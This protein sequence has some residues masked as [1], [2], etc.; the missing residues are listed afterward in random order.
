MTDEQALEI[1]AIQ[2]DE[3][4]AIRSQAPV[5]QPAPGMKPAGAP[6]A[7]PPATPPAQSSSPQPEGSPKLSADAERMVQAGLLV[8]G[9]NGTWT[10]RNPALQSFAD[11]YNRFE[12]Y[13][14]ATARRL[15]T[16]FDGYFQERVG[17]LGVA[18]VD[19]VKEMQTQIQ[20]L[21]E[22]LARSQQEQGQSRVDQWAQENSS[23]LF[24]NG[25]QSQL[26]PYAEKYNAFAQQIDAMARQMGQSL[27]TVQI[28][29]RTIEMLTAAGFSPQQSAQ[30]QMAPAQQQPANPYAQA[31]QQQPAYPQPM[32]V[33]AQPSPSFIQQAAQTAP[34]LQQNRLTEHIAQQPNGI[35]HLST[36]KSGKPKLGSL[37]AFQQQNGHAVT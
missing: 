25:D 17:Q 33:P 6:P 23:H 26:T 19:T 37:I 24:V 21:Q 10:S 28:H 34:R 16:D 30:P 7:T 35:P 32:Q 14:Q 12:A 9:E 4:N 3:A 15:V 36:G 18:T 27:D 31:A 20:S 13:S 11:E 29:D 8:R 22:Q 5:T 2:I 1:L